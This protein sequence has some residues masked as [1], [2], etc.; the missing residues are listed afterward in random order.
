M[1]PT[2]AGKTL[3]ITG[4]RAASG[5]RSRCAPRATAPMSSSPPRATC[6]TRSCPAPST[7]RRR[8]SRPPAARRWRS[9]ATSAKKP[10]CS[11]A[12]DAAVERFGGID[13]LVNNASA[14]S[15]TGTL[16]TPMKRFDLMYGVNVRGTFLCLA[17]LPAAPAAS[18]D[19][20]HILKLSPPL[21]M[22][23]K[24]VRPARGLHHGQVRHEHVRARHGRGVP[25][26]RRGGQR[27][28]AAHGD[29]AP[30]RWR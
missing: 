14:I 13:I 27:A 12:V 30:P 1:T 2:L 26:A 23:P 5:W 10:T 19:N 18:A 20:P 15:L 29:R 28:V 3:F 25:R 21:N 9:S 8:R 24:L 22:D 17:G 4:A 16:E 6:P 11:A 7:P